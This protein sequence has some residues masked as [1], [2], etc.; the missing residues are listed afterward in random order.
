MVNMRYQA[1]WTQSLG[2]QPAYP[3][4][5]DPY[6]VEYGHEWF[7]DRQ[8]AID[9]AHTHDLYNEGKVYVKQLFDDGIPDDWR[10]IEAI[11]CFEDGTTE[12]ESRQE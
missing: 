1:E 6:A 10:V 8:V 9:W 11:Y 2:N 4:D 12:T 5:F 3:A 7:S